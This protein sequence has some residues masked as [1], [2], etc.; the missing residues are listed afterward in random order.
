MGV[1]VDDRVTTIALQ[2]LAIGV[3][4]VLA[5]VGLGILVTVDAAPDLDEWWNGVVSSFGFLQP[6][7]LVMDFVGGGW[8]AAFVVPLAGVALMLQSWHARRRG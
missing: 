1:S 4:L 2:R 7:A 3:L 6:L 5:A 8:S